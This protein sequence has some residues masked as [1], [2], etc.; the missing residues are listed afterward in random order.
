MMEINLE[1]IVNHRI[2]TL[3]S[4][5]KRQVY[6]IIAEKKLEITPEQWVVMY[7]LWQEDGLSIGEI[8]NRSKKDFAN[9]TRI[10]DRLKKL[11]YVTKIKS[12]K[13]GRS[14]NVFILPKAD[15]IKN[16][17]QTCWEKTSDMA[18][19]GISE[20]EQKYLLEIFDKIENNVLQKM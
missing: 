4:L 18:L 2:A 6:K 14:F 8:A 5:L 12:R 13:D 15:E 9:I 10:V 11:E 20:S 7:Y 1:N 17:I 16:D 19:E 3:A